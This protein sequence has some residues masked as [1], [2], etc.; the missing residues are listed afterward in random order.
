MT[1][2]KIKDYEIEIKGH[3]GYAESGCDIVCSALS[4]L[5][6]CLKTAIE[7]AEEEGKL[8]EYRYNEKP[9]YAKI[10][11]VPCDFAQKEIDFFLSVIKSGFEALSV[12][13]PDN[14]KIQDYKT[15]GKNDES[16][17]F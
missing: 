16:T 15:K 5:T 1:Q 17:D 6:Y 13:Y 2:I 11:C 8:K 7:T 9:G 3:A 10:R 12:Q 14:V 4:M